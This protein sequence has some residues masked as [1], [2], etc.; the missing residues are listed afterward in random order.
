MFLH[1]L[2]SY[3]GK[4]FDRTQAF[5]DVARALPTV[6]H[7]IC[8]SPRANA[9]FPVEWLRL[10]AL[11]AEGQGHEPDFS[12]RVSFSDPMYIM[13]TSGTTGLPKCVVQ[14][15]GVS[16]NQL[17]E[18]VLHF[19]I[20]HKDVVLCYSSLSWMMWC[21]SMNVLAT[22]ATL[23]IF[24]GAPVLGQK[25][26]LWDIVAIMKVTVWLNSSR[27]LD[28]T[29]KASFDPT[30]AAGKWLRL[31]T[32]TGSVLPPEAAEYFH[33][34]LP[35]VVVASGSGGTEIN[36]S[37]CLSNPMSPVFGGGELPGPPLGMDVDVVSGSTL[38]RVVGAEGE[39]ALFSAAPCLP[40]YF[41]NDK[42]HERYRASYFSRDPGIWLHGDWALRT[43]HGGFLILGRSDATLNP[44]G[45]RIG[46]RDYYSV[47]EQI[48]GVRILDSVVVGIPNADRSDEEVALFV[49]LPAGE[50]LTDASISKIRS[51][52][53][54]KLSPKHVPKH[55]A[56]VSAIPINLNMKK[57]EILVRDLVSGKVRSSATPL[58]NPSSVDDFVAWADKN[59]KAK[60]TSK[61]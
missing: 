13:F 56:Q 3:G 43:P 38:Q 40:L 16:L 49:V 33:K 6:R 25:F 8:V 50:T 20:S 41:L 31:I 35:H 12:T 22:G 10:D 34:I 58:S 17:K 42:N 37:L 51:T 59:R 4:I 21:Y 28:A 29:R 46:T 44:G 60:T 11:I 61:L 14:S 53:R 36:G 23:C 24:D 18:H 39:L 2:S 26:P 54:D 1:F 55:I 57:M 47:V 52:I 7:T 9:S 48:E 27:Y 15:F 45:V 5:R 30:L 19:D 32:S